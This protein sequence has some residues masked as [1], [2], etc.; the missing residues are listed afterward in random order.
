VGAYNE[1]NLEQIAALQPDL[2]ISSAGM[3]DDIYEKLSAIAPT[4]PVFD[5]GAADAL[6]T[7]RTVADL[8]G[9]TAVLEEKI[10]TYE[11]RIADIRSRLEPLLPT[12]EVSA[13]GVYGESIITTRHPGWTSVMALN[14]LGI[15]WSKG[16]LAN[17]TEESFSSI[18]FENVPELDG[19]VIFVIDP[20]WGIEDLQ[21]TGIL[22]TT[23]AAKAGQMFTVD[24]GAWYRGGIAG[25]NL[26]LDDIETYLLGREIDTSGEFR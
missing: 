18:S 26:V 25:L 16:L 20:N 1:P 13:F 23:F 10:A 8:V 12:L 24:D 5:I 21:A 11:A 19:D 4:V 9:K 14:D 3:H 7:S 6:A 15:T 2:I 17:S 22:E